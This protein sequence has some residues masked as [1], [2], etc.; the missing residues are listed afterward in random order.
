MELVKNIFFNTDKIVENSDVKITYAGYLFQN[1][2][3][4]VTIH[5]GYGQ[6]WENSQDIEM[7]KT[8]LG[9]QATIHVLSYE[10]L[11]MC[12]KNTYGEWD[13]NY[14]NN[15]QFGIEKQYYEDEDIEVEQKN[16]EAPLVV[17]NTPSWG[18]LIKK[19]FENFVNYIAK[20]FGK[21]TETVSND[22]KE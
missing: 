19:T 5:Y 16:I 18:E 21:S 14:G 1:Q 10:Q 7:E 22:N 12:F 20:L 17:Y 2:S 13:N 15:Y 8:E 6:N 3:E 11:N 9:Y 4:G